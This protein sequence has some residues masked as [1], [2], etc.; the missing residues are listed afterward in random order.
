MS[1]KVMIINTAEQVYVGEPAPKAGA[2]L[3]VVAASE[4]DP[5]LLEIVGLQKLGTFGREAR[6][7]LPTTVI[8]PL[9]QG[10]Y[11]GVAF[12]PPIF[13]GGDWGVADS[14]TMSLV[15]VD[16]SPKFE[17]RIRVHRPVT[18]ELEESGSP[19]VRSVT[20][21]VTSSQPGVPPLAFALT[22]DDPVYVTDT[23]SPGLYRVRGE[24]PDGA[25]SPVGGS[26]TWAE[27]GG[28]EE[29]DLEIL[30]P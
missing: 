14:V 24:T 8:N 11:D 20:V 17:M 19:S 28:S 22:P 13:L 12:N 3:I 5:A 9:F 18:F 29:A 23:L 10:I 21:E 7:R 16:G 26:I 2:E 1:D 6:F 15:D 30:P 27:I 25:V 4:Y